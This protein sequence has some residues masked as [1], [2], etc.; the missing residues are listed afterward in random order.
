M[1][2]RRFILILCFLLFCFLLTG[3]T[4]SGFTP[5]DA[6]STPLAGSSVPAAADSLY[7]VQAEP[8]A[9]YFRYYDEP[10]LACEWRTISRTQ[11]QSYEQALLDAL[12]AGP[13]GSIP[14]L[15]PL[16]PPGTR[17]LSTT[18][19]GHMLYV[20]LSREIMD[21][22]M[23]EPADWQEYDAW[24]R[25]SPLRRRLCMQSIVATITENCDIDQVQILVEQTDSISGSLR[26]RQNYF[27]DDSEDSVLAGPMVRDSSLLLGVDNSISY[28]LQL[29]SEHNWA[30]LYRFLASSDGQRPEYEEAVRRL[31]ALPSPVQFSVSPS[32]LSLDGQRATLQVHT[33]AA[34][35]SLSSVG[36]NRIIHLNR[37]NGFWRITLAQ[38]EHL[39]EVSP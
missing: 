23:D 9:L 11:S 2:H 13:S 39:M 31:E 1:R 15:T 18:V 20:T 21:T 35:S 5:R 32:T 26:L 24:F 12:V 30:S 3:C 29:F 10:Y 19:N 8:V 25:E 27:L 22:Y 37:E 17:V 6:L 7:R 33:A 4:V 28:I 14:E 38:L 36:K 34:G 16:F